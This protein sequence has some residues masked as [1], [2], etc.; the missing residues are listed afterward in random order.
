MRARSLLSGLVL[1]VALAAGSMPALAQK[2]ADTLR[3]VFRDGVP[4]IDPYYN[5]QRT[6][7]VI[8]HQVWDTLVYR[9]PETFL[10]KPLLATEWKLVNDTTLEFTIRQGVKFHDG[11]TLSADDVVYTLNTVSNP[12]S[13]VATPSNYNWIDKAEK[14]DD[15]HVRV[16]LKKPTPAALEYFSL[17]IPI[18]PKAYREKVGAEGYAKAP[19]G[20]GPYRITKVETAASVEF[21]RFEDYWKDSPKGRPA[22]KKMLVRFVPDAAT[23]MTELLSGRTDWLWNM[24]PDQFDAVGRMPNLQ[25]TR[26][27]SMRVGYLSIDASGRSGAGNPLTNLKVRQAIWHAIDRETIAKQ[28]VTGGSRVPVAPCYPNQFGCDGN[29]AVKYEYNPAKAKQLL[30]EAGFPNGFETELVTY[31]LPQWAAATQNYL[32]AVGIRAKISQLQVA[33]AIQR[34]WRGENPLYLGSWGSYSVN[35]VSAILPN[36]FGGGNDDY[37]RDPE[38]QKLLEAGGSSNDPAT[39]KTAYSAAI[40]RIT[41]QA[42]WLPMHTYVTTYGFAKNLAFNPYP[43]ELPRFYLAKWQ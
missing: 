14:I 20:A 30:A 2:S 34:A 22:I 16:L 28:L 6:G 1:S 29:A 36:M 18:W 4:N 21:E 41:E 43:D 11:S 39:R 7:L 19:V 42:Y 10:P 8:S 15:F 40:K 13:K 9:D 27:E 12:D 24:N 23:E 3:I 33:A 37:A 35:D 25:A 31:V 38:L 5:S 26:A 32:Q 17:V